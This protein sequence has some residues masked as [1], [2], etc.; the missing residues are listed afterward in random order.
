MPAAGWVVVGVAVAVL[1]IP[2]TVGAVAA[3]KFTGIEGSSLRKADVTA[4]GQ[5]QVA[6]A[7]PSTFF[8]SAETLISGAAYAPVVTPP[9]STALVIT[10]IRVDTFL[11]VDPS[12]GNDFQFIVEQ[13]TDCTGSQVGT[14]NQSLHP[15]ANGLTDIQLGPGLGLPA[16]DALCASAAGLRAQM[17]VSGYSVP[18]AAV[19][20]S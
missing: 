16:G 11:G 19:P 15:A 6:A 18:P 5:L 9:A 12:S 7:D 20:A 4:A 2:T 17:T 1:L 3:L 10:D 13:G 8:Q 14:F